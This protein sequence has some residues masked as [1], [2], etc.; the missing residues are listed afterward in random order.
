MA[1]RLRMAREAK[2]IQQWVLAEQLGISA[3]FLSQI[4]LGRRTPTAALAKKISEILDLPVEDIFRG[5]SSRGGAE[6]V[7]SKACDAV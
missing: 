5:L 4:E 3:G 7:G 6:H 1:T 2:G